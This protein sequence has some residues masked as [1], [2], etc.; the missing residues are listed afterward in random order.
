MMTQTTVILE[1]DTP[2]TGGGGY[3]PPG[4]GDGGDIDVPPFPDFGRVIIEEIDSLG[5]DDGDDGTIPNFGVDDEFL[6]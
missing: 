2:S 1:E 4:G 6:S 3:A 5:P